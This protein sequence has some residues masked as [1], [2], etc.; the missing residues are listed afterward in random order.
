MGNNSGTF[1]AILPVPRSGAFTGYSPRLQKP[2]Y[3]IASPLI[4]CHTFPP[5]ALTVAI[6]PFLDATRKRV[7]EFQDS[8][9]SF[10]V[11]KDRVHQDYAS[12]TG[13]QLEFIV[14]TML[15]SRAVEEVQIQ[16]KNNPTEVY[17]RI[18]EEA[19][20]T[21]EEHARLTELNFHQPFF[22]LGLGCEAATT[23]TAFFSRAYFEAQGRRGEK[24]KDPFSAYYR[25]TG[26]FMMLGHGKRDMT[27]EVLKIAFGHAD[28]LHT[29]MPNHYALKEAGYTP[30]VSSIAANSLR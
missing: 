30:D 18:R 17:R 11:P 8:G 10:L 29:S 15:A 27:R 24:D 20:C 23:A 13:S 2:L 12:L 19:L 28:A 4:F 9:M 25:A 6:F 1:K 7:E 3:K 26:A 21:P 14:D 22:I 5:F 16:L